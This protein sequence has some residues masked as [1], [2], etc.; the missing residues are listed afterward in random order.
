MRN[1]EQRGGR[2]GQVRKLALLDDGRR[3]RR[4]SVP[5]GQHNKDCGML[6]QWEQQPPPLQ[7]GTRAA[8][9][10]E[11]R[12]GQNDPKMM[13]LL[14]NPMAYEELHSLL[15]VVSHLGLMLIGPWRTGFYSSAQSQA[16]QCDLLMHFGEDEADATEAAPR[17]NGIQMFMFRT[18]GIACSTPRSLP[19]L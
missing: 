17:P 1:T 7:T 12:V 8:N 14:F 16:M 3:E 19:R 18:V 4:I 10:T 2:T 6:E 13:V 9:D 15:R 5:Q 11:T